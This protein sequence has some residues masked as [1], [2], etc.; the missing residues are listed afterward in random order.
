MAGGRR[1][2]SARAG[3]E[4]SIARATEEMS[5]NN[6]RSAG[7][8]PRGIIM[9]VSHER[10]PIIPHSDFGDAGCCGCLFGVTQG[11]L[12]KIVCNECQVVV[13]TVPASD[14]QRTLD[15]MEL[16]GDVASAV[17]PHCGA[18]HLAPG[19]SR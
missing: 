19:F 8:T 4:E 17:C 1:K 3:Q 13:R 15:E 9:F 2:K 5:R 16:E 11:D 10:V 7:G 6:R 14:L 12:A 18:T